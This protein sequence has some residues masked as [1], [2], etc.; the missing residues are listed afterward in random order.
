LCDFL[1]F[2]PVGISLFSLLMATSS[3][4]ILYSITSLV[5]FLLSASGFHFSL[6]M[7]L[8]TLDLFLWLF[9]TY[10]AALHWE[11]QRGN[12][13]R[14]QKKDRQYNCQKK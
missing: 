12:Q 5:S 10:L 3:L 6:C 8:L 13:K 2:R 9:A 7:M 11:H 1:V 4:S 14:K